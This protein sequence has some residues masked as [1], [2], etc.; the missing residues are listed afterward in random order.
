MSDITEVIW[1]DLEEVPTVPAEPPPEVAEAQ[2]RDEDG[3]Q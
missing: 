1:L 2:K 3:G